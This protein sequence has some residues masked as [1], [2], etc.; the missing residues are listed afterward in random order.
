MYP[1]THEELQAFSSTTG[2][3]FRRSC[4]A[5]DRTRAVQPHFQHQTRWVLASTDCRH[6]DLPGCGHPQPPRT[7]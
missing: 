5:H 7:G 1:A 6:A 2:L 4:I 3:A